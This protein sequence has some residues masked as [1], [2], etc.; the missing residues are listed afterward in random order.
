MNKNTGN[1]FDEA[2]H[3]SHALSVADVLRILN[4]S[5]RQGLTSTEAASRLK[6]VG[7]NIL[8]EYRD[9]SSWMRF[10]RQWHQPL[11]YILNAAAF[12]TLFLHEYVDASVIFGVV[13][14]NVT[15]G[16]IQESK[17]VK[18]LTALRQTLQVEAR[19]VRDGG[20]ERIAA[21][22]LVPGDIL[23]LEAGDKVSADVRL[24]ESNEYRVNES[25]L[26]GESLPVEKDIQPVSRE[27]GL[28]DRTC[29]SYA[30]T[31]VSAGQAKAVVVAT[32]DATEIGR[33]SELVSQAEE[34]ETPL[35]RSI[36]RFS[37]ILLYIILGLGV[38]GFGAGVLRGE[39]MVEMLMAAIALA[40]GAI[41]E[42]LPAAVTVI[43]AIGVSRMAK[44]KAVIRR[45][46]AVETLGG[47]TVI[48]TDKTGTLTVN[49]MTVSRIEVLDRQYELTGQGYEFE[50]EIL[51][52]TGSKDNSIVSKERDYALFECLKA[53]ALCNDATFVMQ[54]N[55]QTLI[56][57]PT[58]GALL[59]SAVKIG[60]NIDELFLQCKRI[61]AIPF[62]S[63]RQYMATL[64]ECGDE[65]IIYVKGAAERIIEFCTQALGSDNHVV[66]FDT[67]TARATLS[68]LAEEGMRVLGFAYSHS[69]RERNVVEQSDLSELVFLGFQAMIDPPRKEAV[70]AVDAC[71]KAGI[72]VVMITGDHAHTALAIAESFNIPNQKMAT[73]TFGRVMTGEQLATLTDDEVEQACRSV[74][75]FAR[76]APEQKLRLVRAFQHDHAI[77]AMTGDGVNDAPALK[78][79]DIGTAMGKTGTEAAK[80]AADMVLTDD[81]F[82]TIEAAVEEGR[83]VFDNLIKFIVWNLPIN[84][85]EGLVV[86]CALFLGITLPMTP[87]QI[88]WINM[89]TAGSLGIMLAFEPMESDIMERTPRDPQV[90][91]LS[92]DLVLRITVVGVLLLVVVFGLFF[93]ERS[94]NASLEQARTVSVNVFVV[95]SSLYLLNCRS[96]RHPFWRQNVRGNLWIPFGIV[97]MMILQVL[98]TYLPVM[99]DLFKSSPLS[100]SSWLRIFMVSFTA[101]LLVELEKFIRAKFVPQT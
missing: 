81:N 54:D 21:H 79:A 13:L 97:L 90:S 66:C 71:M 10:V 33:I 100:W 80:E 15:L 6:L 52:I 59:V 49:Q 2:T 84:L 82:A 98:Y 58:E 50:G 18:A 65:N 41:P 35:T 87:V 51:H 85:G 38:A 19:V 67:A 16:Y 40:V 93:Y 22:D 61:D 5:S 25:S 96:L 45:L 29:M 14:V 86:L 83:A 24:V 89:T 4:T 23:F 7:P 95:V 101:M 32:G 37:Q 92:F 34:L 20:T 31:L 12:I 47:T 56:G 11:L 39:P 42:G 1:A 57:D 99:N 8:R 64:H 74:S 53:G 76:V 36:S 63:E 91:I 55:V 88:L 75:V 62:S 48:C 9:E 3:N 70:H 60:I 26:T 27:V 72:R 44:R 94:L 17:A 43:L 46:P 78:Q 68:T 28:A 30:G 73:P 77:V 69:S